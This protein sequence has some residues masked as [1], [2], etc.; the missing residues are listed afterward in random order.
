MS[1]GARARH[2]RRG[3]GE[4]E[5]EGGKRVD[6]VADRRRASGAAGGEP[7]RARGHAHEDSGRGSRRV[8]GHRMRMSPG[9]APAGNKGLVPSVSVGE[10]GA[11]DT[12]MQNKR[13]R[14]STPQSKLSRSS[15]KGGGGGGPNGIPRRA[16]RTA[17]GASAVSANRRWAERWADESAVAV[18]NLRVH[19][20]ADATQVVHDEQIAGA[21]CLRPRRNEHHVLAR[22]VGR[23]YSGADRETLD[24]E[25]HRHRRAWERVVEE[26][27]R[28]DHV[29][30]QQP[31]VG[32]GS[33]DRGRRRR[34]R[35]NRSRRH[36]D[37]SRRCG[38]DAKGHGE[39]VETE[40]L[41]GCVGRDED[42]R[43][44]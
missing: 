3:G 32:C 7:G 19:T 14:P 2:G 33:A 15:V 31:E 37:V 8:S 34:G 23:R 40:A 29:S 4:R 38:D 6:V 24:R 39:H 30:G 26:R 21:V 5:V 16:D 36:Q 42:R 1:P 44:A 41:C 20:T 10:P 18:E 12:D 22:D 9:S 13:P 25:I 35:R 11:R 28:V 27:H 17:R 43:R